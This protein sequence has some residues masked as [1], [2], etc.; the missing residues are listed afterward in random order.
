ME[1]F[2][3]VEQQIGTAEFRRRFPFSVEHT[4]KAWGKNRA[5]DN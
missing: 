2:R 5:T 3:K 4:R 1:G